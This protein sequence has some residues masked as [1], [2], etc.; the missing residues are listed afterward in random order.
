MSSASVFH[1]VGVERRCDCGS[2]ARVDGCHRGVTVACNG[3]QS[4][5]S[6]GRRF[7]VAGGRAVAVATGG[8]NINQTQPDRPPVERTQENGP[9]LLWCQCRQ[10]AL[11]V[12]NFGTYSTPAFAEPTMCLPDLESTAAVTLSVA[13]A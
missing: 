8:V 3:D 7:Q 13:V 5:A 11:T 6:A 4:A 10:V 12:A 1:A 2:P 9:N